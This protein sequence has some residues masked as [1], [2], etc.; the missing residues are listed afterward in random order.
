M[1]ISVIVL[2]ILLAAVVIKSIF[3]IITT[4]ANVLWLGKYK[5]AVQSPR[6]A[7]DKKLF[8]LL[9]VYL[10]QKLIRRVIEDYYNLIKDKDNVFLII[11]TTGKETDNLTNSEST[12]NIA[13]DTIDN[14]RAKNI[15]IIHYPHNGGSMPEQ[16]NYAAQEIIK[17]YG[18]DNIWFFTLNIDS[19]YNEQAFGDIINLVNSKEKIYQHSAFFLSNFNCFKG[20]GRLFLQAAA[21]FQSRWTIVHEIKRYRV[22]ASGKFFS[23]YQL[24]HAVGH[25]LLIPVNI[26]R[27]Y[28]FPV[29][30]IIEDSP[31]GYLLRCEGYIIN[32]VQNIETADSPHSFLEH[33]KQKYTWSFGPMGYL[34]YF[35]KYRNNFKAGYNSN[36]FKVLVLTAQGLLSAISWQLSSWVF[37][38]LI[39]GLFYVGNILASIIISALVLYTV[40]YIIS[41]LYFKKAGFISLSAKSLVLLYLSLWAVILIHS[42]PANYALLSILLKRIGLKQNITKF[43]TEHLK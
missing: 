1:D 5:S 16:L 8:L 29:D 7:S 34:K 2:G 36:K 3:N 41:M 21:I 30:E 19:K 31:F 32:P 15:L 11:I 24:A 39:A 14:L 37:L 43:K 23:K 17:Y 13:K 18:V 28:C 4:L 20:W 35:R 42:L 10:E 33:V 22:N 40:D 25:G 6:L 26:F 12:F 27:K 38:Y 9:P